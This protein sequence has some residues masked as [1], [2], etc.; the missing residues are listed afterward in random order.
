MGGVSRYRSKAD[1]FPGVHPIT[2]FLHWSVSPFLM[3]L[4]LL[5]GVSK[6]VAIGGPPT[7]STQPHSQAVNP[8]TSATFTVQA[9]SLTFPTYQWR[10][11][12]GNVA[13]NISGAKSASYT[14]TNAGSYSVVVANDVGSVTSLVVTLTLRVVITGQPLAKT[15]AVGDAVQFT[16]TAIG[17][18]L[19][20]LLHD[21]PVC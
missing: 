7:I 14:T 21:S 11:N 5:G 4:L 3:L 10:T 17:S 6:G 1:C 2:R 19:S 13:G 12:V 18:G 9:N 16:V 20:M 15:V 8:G